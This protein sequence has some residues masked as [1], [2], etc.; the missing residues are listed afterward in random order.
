MNNKELLANINRAY[1]FSCY[2]LRTRGDL[3][4]EAEI[5]EH[6]GLIKLRAALMR[7]V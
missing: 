6:Y 5:N 3:V 7:S 4:T 1:A 2:Y